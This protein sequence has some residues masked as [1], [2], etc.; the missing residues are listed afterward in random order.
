MELK[1]AYVEISNRALL[2]AETNLVAGISEAAGFYAYHAF[3]SMG[4]ALCT[5]VGED[6]SFSHTKKIHQFIAVSKRRGLRNKIGHQVLGVAGMLADRNQLL[7]P[8]Q[9]IDNQVKL[10]SQVL[11]QTEAKSLLKR[12]KGICKKVEKYLS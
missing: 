12:V 9:Q 5:S 10:P 3:E 11:S 1:D 7:Y 4:G 8:Q 2:T 6:Y